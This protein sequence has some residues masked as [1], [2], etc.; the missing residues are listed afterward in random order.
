MPVLENAFAS[1][2]EAAPKI[3]PK[4]SP[5]DEAKSS[6][7]LPAGNSKLSQKNFNR[8]ST[9]SSSS[10]PS[11]SV[12]SSS[13]P[14]SSSTPSPSSSSSSPSSSSSSSPSPSQKFDVEKK[15]GTE[16][17]FPAILQLRF[18]SNNVVR[19]TNHALIYLK[20]GDAAQEVEGEWRGEGRGGGAGGA[21]GRVLLFRHRRLL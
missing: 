12:A 19:Y 10:V 2:T 5:K 13:K 9:L 14:S 8:T 11:S 7:K 21:V 1:K 3:S 20:L 16:A 4:F 17:Q 6:S 15:L 18:C